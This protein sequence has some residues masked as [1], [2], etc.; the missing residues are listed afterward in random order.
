MTRPHMRQKDVSKKRD[1][2]AAV[3]SLTFFA[4]LC[5]PSNSCGMHFDCTVVTSPCR[6]SKATA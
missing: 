5:H 4:T 1:G 3:P 2:H 6:K